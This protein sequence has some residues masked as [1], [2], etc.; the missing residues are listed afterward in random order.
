M[1]EYLTAAQ[2]LLEKKQGTHSAC[3]EAL[4]QGDLEHPGTQ[5][6]GQKLWFRPSESVPLLDLKLYK[7]RG[8]INF[9][10]SLSYTI[11]IRAAFDASLDVGDDMAFL[12]DT[13]NMVEDCVL[14]R[15]REC[16]LPGRG[17]PFHVF[18]SSPIL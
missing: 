12:P 18:C 4:A 14:A 8:P 2:F 17:R 15:L 1:N 6:Y 9:E 16:L 3:R 10:T 13:H 5:Q 7:H 11:L